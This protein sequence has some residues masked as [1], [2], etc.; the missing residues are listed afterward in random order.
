MCQQIAIVDD[1]VCEEDE[2]FSLSLFTT[3]SGVIL[4]SMT[5]TGMVMI[6]DNDGETIH[7]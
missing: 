1:N 3:D 7:N 5:A 2:V 6:I 4:N